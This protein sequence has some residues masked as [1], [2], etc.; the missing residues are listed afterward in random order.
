MMSRLLA[1]SAA[2]LFA[3]PGAVHA[4]P[5]CFNGGDSNSQ[6]FLW[7]S[8]F[9]MLVPTVAIGSLLYW[10]YRRTRA[11]EQPPPP[12]APVSDAA[13]PALRVVSDR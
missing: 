4:C 6:A 5:M 12:P 3:L 1:I 7:G 11:L 8:L 2:L 10:A 13:R 9:L